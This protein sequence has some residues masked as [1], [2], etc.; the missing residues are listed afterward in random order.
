MLFFVIVYILSPIDLIPE[1]SF[2]VF[3]LL[4]DLLSLVMLLLGVGYWYRTLL[5]GF[6]GN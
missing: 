6:M 4:D 2:G 1:A 5:A 3:G